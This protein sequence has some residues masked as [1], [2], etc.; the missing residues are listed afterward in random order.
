MHTHCIVPFLLCSMVAEVAIFPCLCHSL[1]SFVPSSLHI[2][3]FPT[4][5]A[6]FSLHFTFVCISGAPSG[7]TVAARLLVQCF[8]TFVTF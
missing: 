4:H 7:I 2:L 8:G 5:A 3:H 1:H 6:V